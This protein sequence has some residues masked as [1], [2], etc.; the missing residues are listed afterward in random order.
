[1]GW[2]L[3]P[4]QAAAIRIDYAIWGD[5]QYRIQVK[6]AEL[7]LQAKFVELQG[8]YAALTGGLAQFMQSPERLPELVMAVNEV[9]TA[10]RGTPIADSLFKIPILST[11]TINIEANREAAL[12][13]LDAVIVSA[14]SVMLDVAEYGKGY[15]PY[16]ISYVNWLIAWE[17]IKA[18]ATLGA[19]ALLAAATNS[20][21][22]ASLVSKL[23]TAAGLSQE[24]ADELT[25]VIAARQRILAQIREVQRRRDLESSANRYS[26]VEETA[27]L[28][29]ERKLEIRL[30]RSPTVAA[31]WCSGGKSYDHWTTNQ[32]YFDQ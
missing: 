23:K 26:A 21:R 2:A 4:A 25:E 7:C 29:Q 18:G 14:P 12:R 20:E 28:D 9:F 17:I 6:A 19:S 16:A 15:G 1:M 11:A 31:D 5:A 8:Q 13:S 27:G 30:K 22:I 32:P 10:L 3:F 24:A